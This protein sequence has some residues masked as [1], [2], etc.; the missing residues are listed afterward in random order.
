MAF[1]ASRKMSI[2]RVAREMDE[3]SY[4]M[5]EIR[6]VI[7]VKR[8]KGTSYVTLRLSSRSHPAIRM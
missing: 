8:G 5:H 4:R 3:T 7:Q 1:K 2:G 6:T